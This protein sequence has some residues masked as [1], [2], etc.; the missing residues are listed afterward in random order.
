MLAGPKNASDRFFLYF[1]NRF[2]NGLA[3]IFLPINLYVCRK[4][5]D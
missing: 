5:L 4:A 2:S 1:M 3:T